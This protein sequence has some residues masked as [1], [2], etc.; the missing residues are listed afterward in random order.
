MRGVVERVT[1]D[2]VG[3]GLGLFLEL[4]VG[5]N[6][7]LSIAIWVMLRRCLA[8][9]PPL[10][11]AVESRLQVTFRT[12]CTIDSSRADLDGIAYRLSALRIGHIGSFI[13][14]VSE[15]DALPCCPRSRILYEAGHTPYAH[16]CAALADVYVLTL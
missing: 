7:R 14:P 4:L 10:S 16:I 8:T 15:P 3:T 9:R 12:A 5:M 11:Q 2:S 6:I 13:P 1:S